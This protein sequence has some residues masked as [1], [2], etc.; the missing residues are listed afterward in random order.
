MGGENSAAPLECVYECHFYCSEYDGS[1]HD[2]IM[3]YR[4]VKKTKKRIY[5]EAEPYCEE[6]RPPCGDWQDYVVKTFVLDR[7][8]FE[9]EGQAKKEAVRNV[10]RWPGNLLRRA[11]L[12]STP[13]RVFRVSWC[14]SRGNRRRNPVGLSPTSSGSSSRRWWK[15]Q[16]VQGYPEVVRGSELVGQ[17]GVSEW[18]YFPTRIRLAPAGGEWGQGMFPGVNLWG[19]IIFCW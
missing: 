11:P 19:R 8:E 1:E 12:Q 15:C 3:L 6:V 17:C 14:P 9:A 5:V 4:I 16:S 2:S 7:A 10:L 13:S 18:R